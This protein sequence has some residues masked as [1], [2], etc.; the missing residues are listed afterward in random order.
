MTPTNLHLIWV[1][2]PL[3]WFLPSICIVPF[4][5]RQKL[6]YIS[7]H[8]AKTL[9]TNL[10]EGMCRS[11]LS[12][13]LLSLVGVSTPDNGIKLPP[14]PRRQPP[15]PRAPPPQYPP[16]I[17]SPLPPFSLGAHQGGHATTCFLE[18][19]LEGSFKEVLL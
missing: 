17:K 18:G 3:A 6:S 2:F 19:F 7:S 16:P 1:C 5:N 13:M 15:S 11:G 14:L 12:L 4:K 9:A 10:S 8:K